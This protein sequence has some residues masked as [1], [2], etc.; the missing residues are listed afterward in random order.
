[1]A[2]EDCRDSDIAVNSDQWSVISSANL[3]SKRWFL[4][5]HDFTGVPIDRSSSMG[6]ETRCTGGVHV[7]RRFLLWDWT[8][9]GNPVVLKGHGFSR[10]VNA[11]K[12]LRA[13]APEGHISPILPEN[14]S[15][16]AAC[17]APQSILGV[18]LRSKN[19]TTPQTAI[20]TSAMTK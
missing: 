7:A 8:G 19:P 11:T 9:C 6:C 1:M 5:G 10:A 18:P 17:L 4:K 2:E 20:I 13:L 14:R 3:G 12:Q 15:F 16:S